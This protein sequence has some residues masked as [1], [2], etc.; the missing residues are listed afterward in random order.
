MCPMGPDVNT[1][2][3]HSS[4]VGLSWRW[5]HVPLPCTA[6]L[7]VPRAPPPAPVPAVTSRLSV[8]ET[9]SWPSPKAS[10]VG[11]LLYCGQGGTKMVTVSLGMTHLLL[12][13]AASSWRSWGCRASTRQGGSRRDLMVP[14]GQISGFWSPPA[15]PPAGW[16]AAPCSAG[17]FPRRTERKSSRLGLG[18]IRQPM[19]ARGT[20]AL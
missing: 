14:S 18:D 3:L 1:P 19:A 17:A 16:G 10:L 20:R 15:R 8:P 12:A 2:C 5:R 4:P 6:L 11:S 13:C 7:S 9:S